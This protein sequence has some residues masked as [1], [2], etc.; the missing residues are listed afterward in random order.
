[1]TRTLNGRKVARVLAGSVVVALASAPAALAW[2]DHNPPPPP[3]NN[4]PA[5][6]P[7]NPPVD[8]GDRGNRGGDGNWGGMNSSPFNGGRFTG[9]YPGRG[10]M[11]GY[12]PQSGN[13]FNSLYGFPG[14]FGFGGSNVFIQ[15]GGSLL[16]S[17]NTGNYIGPQF[18]QIGVANVGFGYGPNWGYGGGYGGDRNGRGGDGHGD[19]SGDHNT[20]DTHQHG[21]EPSGQQP[22]GQEPHGQ[23]PQ[24]Q[25]PNDGGHFHKAPPT[26]EGPGDGSGGPN[27]SL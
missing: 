8:H 16:L 2:G 1:M 12:G 25:F 22:H 24:G 21:Q 3:L 13:F 19:H 23:P 7:A 9:S 18:V 6:P 20:P 15:S 5:N 27:G 4:P 14:L 10:D 26:L 11:R 17:I